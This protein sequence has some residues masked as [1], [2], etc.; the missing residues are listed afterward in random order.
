MNFKLNKSLLLLAM[1]SAIVI[2]GCASTPSTDEVSKANYG[3]DMRP[4]ECIALTEKAVGYSLKDP[5]SAQ[6]RHAGP[7]VKGYFNS[8]PVLGLKAAFGWLQVGEVNGKNAYGGYV[9]FRQYQA[10]IR[11]GIVIRY[12]I[13]DKDGFCIPE[14]K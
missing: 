13:A 12:C 4:E 7:C 2:S 10:L 9:G 11:D 8:V 5:N 14:G 3:R 6:F 1:V